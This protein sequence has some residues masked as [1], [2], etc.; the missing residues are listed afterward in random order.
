MTP[1]PKHPTAAAVI[2]C[3]R[4]GTFA[5]EA[6]RSPTDA[7]LCVDCGQRYAVVG[8]APGDIVREAFEFLKRHSQGA[9]G[10]AAARMSKG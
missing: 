7:T 10:Y 4:C 5:C 9:I 6:C 2:T 1:C 3:A 8:L